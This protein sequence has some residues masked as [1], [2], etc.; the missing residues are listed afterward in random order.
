MRVIDGPF[1]DF[2]GVVE[3]V[4]YEKSRLRGGG[5]DFRPLD[6]GGTRLRSGRKGLRVARERDGEEMATADTLRL[7]GV[8]SLSSARSNPYEE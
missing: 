7:R 6:A 3:H 1:N 5:H 8:R 2:N 4:N